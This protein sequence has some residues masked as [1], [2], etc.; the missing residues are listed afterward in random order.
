MSNY[1]SK[2]P[3]GTKVGRRTNRTGKELTLLILDIAVMVSM[4]ILIF[5]SL[6]AI[7][8]QYVSPEKSGVLSVI[9]L[10][11]PIIYLLDMVVMFYW[12]VR[13]RWYAAL[14]MFIVVFLGLF[15]LSKY[16]KIDFDRDY[17]T[18]FV[19]RKYTKVMTY[20]VHEGKDS[21]LVEYIDKHNPDIL[22]LQEMNVY[23]ENWRN[24]A[25]KYNTTLIREASTGNQILSKYK[26]V[27]KGLID[28]INP[29]NAVWAD[30]K[31][32]DDTVR[33]IS[34]HLK[35]TAIRLEDTEFL[36]NHKYFTDSERDSK[37]RSIVSR[38]VKNNQKRAAQARKIAEF[39]KSTPYKM[40]ICGDFNDV[41]L[42]YTYR[43]IYRGL[44]DTF[45]EMANGFAYTFN[46]RYNL[47]RIDNILVS[48]SIEVASYDV[49]NEVEMSD[50]YPVIS[51]LVFKK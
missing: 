28:D 24:L 44:D 26:I 19:E 9:A 10:G 30:L 46:T 8:C 50:H 40:I 21:K 51:R 6:T 25:E 13:L 45:S 5:L 18:K 20:N 48:P 12:V 41:P 37:L 3:A 43:T 33:V 39:K 4:A 34:L 42:S 14:A 31:I 32:K 29:M 49:D 22:C 1:Y 23:T 17:D 7:I 27:R 47:L 38:L 16:Y 2:S 36:E 15:Y 11:V 35:S